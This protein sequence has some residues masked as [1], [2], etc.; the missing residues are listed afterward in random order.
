MS[1]SKTSLLTMNIELTCSLEDCH[2]KGLDPVADGLHGDAVVT[3]R[4]QVVHREGRTLNI[5]KIV[6]IVKSYKRVVFLIFK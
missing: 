2:A 6:K 4:L 1:H 3:A 5:G